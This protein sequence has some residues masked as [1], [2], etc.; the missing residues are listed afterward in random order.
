M[1]VMLLWACFSPRRRISERVVCRGYTVARGRRVTSF[2]IDRLKMTDY[3]SHVKV[4]IFRENSLIYFRHDR[5]TKLNFS[6]VG[7]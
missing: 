7:L 5:Y 6:L 4:F 3:Y 2:S 1:W